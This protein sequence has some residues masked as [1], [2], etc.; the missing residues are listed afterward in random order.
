VID[1]FEQLF[2]L[3]A[4]DFSPLYACVKDLSDLDANALLPGD[5]PVA[6]DTTR[7]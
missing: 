1:S 3:T 5:Q 6:L 2:G 7:P 4:P